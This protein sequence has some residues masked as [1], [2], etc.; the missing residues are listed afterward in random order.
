MKCWF[1]VGYIDLRLFLFVSKRFHCLQGS[2]ASSNFLWSDYKIIWKLYIFRFG[3][4]LNF[5]SNYRVQQLFALLLFH[6]RKVFSILWYLHLIFEKIEKYENLLHSTQKILGK[7]LHLLKKK[8]ENYSLKVFKFS[9]DLMK[10]VATLMV[11]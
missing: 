9:L 2:H 8:R 1:L 4:V 11:K 5:N 6:V 3:F 10:R 7:Y